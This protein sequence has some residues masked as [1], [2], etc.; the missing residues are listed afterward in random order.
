MM[1]SPLSS[2]QRRNEVT[3]ISVFQIRTVPPLNPPTRRPAGYRNSS[4]SVSPE[5]SSWVGVDA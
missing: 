2:N 4:T 3:Y 1:F 5:S